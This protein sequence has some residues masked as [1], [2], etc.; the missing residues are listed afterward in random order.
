[1]R[2]HVYTH[3]L[4]LRAPVSSSCLCCHLRFHL[5]PH[6]F[7]PPSVLLPNPSPDARRRRL[8]FLLPRLSL[9]RLALQRLLLLAL[10][11]LCLQLQIVHPIEPL[12][13]RGSRALEAEPERL[14]R[15]T[16]RVHLTLAARASA[17]RQ[18]AVVH[19]AHW[20]HP[21]LDALTSAV[22]TVVRSAA[23]TSSRAASATASAASTSTAASAASAV[24]S[25]AAAPATASPCAVAPAHH[26]ACA[27]QR[28]HRLRPYLRTPLCHSHERRSRRLHV[29][30][31]APAAALLLPVFSLVV[32]SAALPLPRLAKLHLH[33][34]TQRQPRPCGHLHRRP[35]L[36]CLLN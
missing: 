13:F 7:L 11:R 35:A 22:S 5:T 18:R 34:L 14:L 36:R 21:I 32:T 26:R 2:P 19:S 20:T 16:T 17:P 30:E 27:I 3:D 29:H 23:A 24:P 6:L 33:V 8:L 9:R 15:A 28:E 25:T 12:F 1:M 4:P 10:R 31:R